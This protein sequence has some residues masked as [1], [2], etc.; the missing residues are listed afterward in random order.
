MKYILFVLYCCFQCLTA[1]AQSGYSIKP[2][3]GLN[4]EKDDIA[5]GMIGDKLIVVTTGEKD[6]VNEYSWN[7]RPLFYLQEATRGN[8]FSQW[9]NPI[10]LFEKRALYDE[11]PCSFDFRDSTLYFSTAHRYGKA[12]GGRLK[13]YTSK[14]TANGWTHPELVSF[15][16]PDADYGHPHFDPERNLLVFSSNR[17]G[18]FGEMDIWYIYKTE[19]G[20]SEVVNPG[21]QVN[22]KGNELFPT[23]YGGNI[24]Y[25]SNA[26]GGMGGYDL[27]KANGKQQ[28]K[29]VIRLEAPF[30]GKED[31]MMIL[32]L[33]D[34]KALLTSNRTG[35]VGGDDIYIITK[36]PEDYE[37]HNFTARL[38]CK[39]LTLPD[40]RITVTNEWKEKMIDVTSDASGNVGIH[41]LLLNRTYKVQLSDID[42]SLFTHCLLY[43]LD[44]T[45]KVIK[46]IRFNSFGFAILEILPF[47]Y[48]NLNLM[49][50][51]DGSMLLPED[52]TSIL[53][54]KIEGQLF[55]KHIGDVGR[56][57]AITILDEMGVP[58]AIAFTNETG[59]FRFTD[60]KPQMEYTFKLAETG[61]AKNILITEKGER[62][63]LP[64]LDAEAH[65]KRINP[66]EVIELVNE[67]NETIFVSPKDIFI[68]NR[69][70]YDYNSSRLTS[71]S[72]V[73]L[74]KLE[75]LLKKNE[76]LNMELRS[77][78]DSRGASDY[79]LS[80]SKKRAD[81]AAIYL[82]SKGI[83]RSRFKASGYGESKLLNE[84]EDGVSCLEPEHS[85][86]RRTEIRLFED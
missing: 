27:M 9:S 31:D 21:E 1:T 22:S 73:Q 36:N 80:L 86:N 5:C 33:N 20:W 63:T 15:C 62:I 10:R 14:L 70:Y 30:N 49:A 51:E 39:G 13:I 45:G 11:G 57:E 53:N 61:A 35:G 75:I 66:T 42:P 16:T 76:K 79:N 29:T 4:T 59:K 43:V 47:N 34:E 64:V 25:S 12:T 56:G 48:A 69:I 52:V 67:F 18:G 81:A 74:D 40:A 84:C 6:L 71:A 82:S 83:N 85:I 60:V 37:K 41:Q 26:V 50:A 3:N 24:Y 19:S 44:D 58:V 77:H 7:A 23:V 46:E 68:I 78:T 72:R 28:W 17:A 54:I 65:Y 2:V 8:D 55:E 32:F 38:D